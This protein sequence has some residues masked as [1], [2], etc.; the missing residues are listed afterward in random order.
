MNSQRFDLLDGVDYALFKSYTNYREFYRR[1]IAKRSARLAIAINR[2]RSKNIIARPSFEITFSV[3]S[4]RASRYS[5]LSRIFIA[6]W[7]HPFASAYLKKRI[8]LSLL[9]SSVLSMHTAADRFGRSPARLNENAWNLYCRMAINDI[10]TCF[11]TEI[12]FDRCTQDTPTLLRFH[13]R[14]SSIFLFF[15]YFL[16]RPTLRLI[17]PDSRS[18]WFA[19]W[20]RFRYRKNVVDLWQ[21]LRKRWFHRFR[22]IQTDVSPDIG[23]LNY[24]RKLLAFFLIAEPG[25]VTFSVKRFNET[26]L[27]EIVHSTAW[28]VERVFIQLAMTRHALYECFTRSFYRIS[29]SPF[30]FVSYNDHCNESSRSFSLIYINLTVDSGIGI[31]SHEA[32]FIG[33]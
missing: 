9:P 24:R 16:K 22:F 12:I 26:E 8:F 15:E 20:V 31:V 19:L 10:S 6:V 5:L 32:S 14:A 33:K 7:R 25:V 18:T 4:N 11:V 2:R 21:G 29:R 17:F 1:F 13:A 27:D 23:P 30:R 28:K 3:D